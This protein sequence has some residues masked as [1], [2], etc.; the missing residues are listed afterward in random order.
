MSV[1]ES[2][3]VIVPVWRNCESMPSVLMAV[4]PPVP[5]RSMSLPFSPPKTC[6]ACGMPCAPKAD[7][8]SP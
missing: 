7:S 2:P 3:I 8:T 1:T 5:V 6:V 4:M